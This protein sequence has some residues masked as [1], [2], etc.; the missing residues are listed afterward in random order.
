MPGKSSLE[1][2][3]HYRDRREELEDFWGRRASAPN[4]RARYRVFGASVSMASNHECAAAAFELSHPQFSQV[5]GNADDLPGYELQFAVDPGRETTDVPDDLSTHMRR[6]GGGDW[7]LIDAGIWGSA[8]I[9]LR[10]RTAHFIL[11]PALARRPDLISS[12][13]LNTVI[14]NLFIGSAGAGMLHASCLLKEGGERML[15]LMAPH[16]TGKSTTALRLV[17]AGYRLLTDS[18]VFVRETSAG[19]QLLGFPVGR[20]KLRADVRRE[21]VAA[22]AAIEEW[23]EPEEVRSETK[24]SLDLRRYRPECVQS[25][26]VLVPP[27]VDLC[28]LERTGKLETTLH[29]A[30]A[31]TVMEAVVAN[32]LYCDRDEVWLPNLELLSRLV[33]GADCFHLAAGTD[34]ASLVGVIEGMGERP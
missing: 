31:Q 15:L 11:S 34:V 23:L 25:E 30:L 1:W 22:N 20:I 32:S 3:R 21:V 26:A 13:M 28:L 24:H 9:D 17:Q 2:H 6:F 29:P 19:T 16:N 5:P 7:L 10:A 12:C 8:H 14:L 4:L 27:C 18:M 33:E